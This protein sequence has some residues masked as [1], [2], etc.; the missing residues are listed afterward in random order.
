MEATTITPVQELERRISASLN[1]HHVPSLRKVT[2]E[3]RDGNIVLRG[4]VYSFYAKQLS[5]HSARL[6]AGDRHVIDEVS[7][8]TPASFRDSFRLRLAASAG[9]ALILAV[10][11]S[12][13]GKSSEPARLP[14]HPVSG[15]VIYQG[16]PA[17]GA[18]VVFHPKNDPSLPSPKAQADNQGNFSLSTYGPADG[19]PVG[20]Y[21]V[22][23]EWFK[24]NTSVV[25]PV[26]GPNLLPAKYS[27]PQTTNVV[28]KVAEG[29]NT[30]PIK[31]V[32]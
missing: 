30:V 13:C 7:V 23:V 6:L 19:A 16:K 28:A 10:T 2:V 3:S 20:E 27:T 31:I 17:A 4:E 1:S 14:L 9:V 5:Q 18:W 8:V 12:G 24:F 29:A 25:D 26:A 11:V 15:R 21:A 32:R 22:T